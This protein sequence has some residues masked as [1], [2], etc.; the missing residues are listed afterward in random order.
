MKNRKTVVVAFLLVAAMLL[1]IGYA[2]L[3]TTL[4]IIGNAHVDIAQAEVNFDNKVY[5]SSARLG[6]STGTG[7]TADEISA[8]NT[9][10][11]T[12]VVNKLATKG[13]YSEF[14]FTIKNDSNV[15]VKIS[16]E[17]TKLSGAENDT[18]S[19]PSIFEVTYEYANDNMEIPSGGEMEVKVTVKIIEA[20]TKVTSGT[21]T[22]E[23]TATAVSD[24]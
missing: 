6:N 13:E 7:G 3:T 8:N 9:D 21:F 2:N 24:T 4:T 5:F 19:N 15:P 10:D 14:Y 16:V 20:V 11:A 18:N 23:L 12:Y 1:G 22:I 17:P